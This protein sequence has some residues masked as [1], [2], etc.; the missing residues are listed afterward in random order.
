MKITDS[1]TFLGAGLRYRWKRCNIAA[2]AGHF[3][4]ADGTNWSGALRFD[5]ACRHLGNF[6][7]GPDARCAGRR[8]MGAWRDMSW[9]GNAVPLLAADRA[10]GSRGQGAD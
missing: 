10:T 8:R 9:L 1:M 4:Q 2:D 5:A 6:I 7:V 3:R